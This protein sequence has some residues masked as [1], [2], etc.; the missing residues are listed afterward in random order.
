MLS[1]GDAPGDLLEEQLGHRAG[2][3]GSPRRYDDAVSREPRRASI[4][5]WSSLALAYTV[6][7]SILFLFAPLGVRQTS[8]SPGEIT[9]HLSLLQAEGAG[10]VVPLL[11]PVAAALVPV[12]MRRSLRVRTVTIAAA[13]ILTLMVI[14]ELTSIGL[15][16]APAAGLMIAA[17]AK[18]RPAPR[19]SASGF[20][21][22]AGDGSEA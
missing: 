20:R 5:R 9:Q 22:P 16:Y 7:A 4:Q 12:L 11:L 1:A 19:P 3:V 17:A 21:G 14:V 13:V 2:H 10:I 15:Y 18:E 6:C 8:A